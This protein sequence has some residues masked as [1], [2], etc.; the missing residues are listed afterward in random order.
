MDAINSER[1][2]KINELAKTLR[3]MGLAK[4]SDD[5]VNIA[6]KIIDREKI[7]MMKE[8]LGN[9]EDNVKKQ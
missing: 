2:Q 3:A 4:T 6:T 7:D 8:V 5:A 9:K 1:L